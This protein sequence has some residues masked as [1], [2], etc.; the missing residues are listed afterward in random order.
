MGSLAET[1]MDFITREPAMAERYKN[2]GF[3]A[4]WAAITKH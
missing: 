2:A 4:F 3:E 1:T